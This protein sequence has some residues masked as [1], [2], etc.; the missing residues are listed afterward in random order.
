M[1]MSGKVVS[2]GVCLALNMQHNSKVC[3]QACRDFKEA[4]RAGHE[5]CLQRLGGLG[6][7]LPLDSPDWAAAGEARKAQAW[8]AAAVACSADRAPLLKWL[9]R[10]RWPPS[11]GAIAPWHMPDSFSHWHCLRT[12]DGTAFEHF[13]LKHEYELYYNAVRSSTI[14]CLE[15][16]LEA[17]CRSPWLCAIAAA[18][19]Q[20]GH[21]RLAARAGCPCDIRVLDIGASSG[22][23]AVLKAVY[24]EGPDS[25]TSRRFVGLNAAALTEGLY[26][27][28]VARLSVKRASMRL[29][30]IAE[31]AALKGRVE[32]LEALLTWFGDNTWLPSLVFKAASSGHLD[33]LQGFERWG[34]RP[35]DWQAAAR[36]AALG[37]HVECL[38]FALQKGARLEGIYLCDAAASRNLDMLRYLVEAGCTPWT[39]REAQAAARAGD[40]EVL[41]FCLRH[42]QP[43]NPWDWYWAMRCARSC[44]SVACVRLLYNFGYEQHRPHEAERHP[45]LFA[46]EHG[47]VPCLGLAVQHSGRPDPKLWRLY[48]AAQCGED[49]LRCVWEMGA[50]NPGDAAFGAIFASQAGALRFAFKVGCPCTMEL[51]WAAIDFNSLECLR[52]VCERVL[53]LGLRDVYDRSV[54]CNWQVRKDL[55]PAI[56]QYIANDVDARMS[57]PLVVWIAEEYAAR[58]R[59]VKGGH[60]HGTDGINWRTALL[61]AR[62]FRR[63]YGTLFQLPA[64]LCEL[65]AVRRARAA[66]LAGA[67]YRA[68]KLARGGRPSPSLPLWRALEALPSEL[69][70]RIAFQAHLVAP[71]QEAPHCPTSLLGPGACIQPFPA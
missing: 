58:A 49:M 50:R 68:G 59:D 70:E 5:H 28:P 57:R 24:E 52:C 69:R 6:E 18:E 48:R 33:C 3:I 2:D 17:G 60:V 65:V 23:L 1:I 56:V 13:I 22:R 46:L 25:L 21:L 55:D 62:L 41:A 53:V 26:D 29:T 42:A 40:S 35:I 67:F 16:L 47:N 32:C 19:G 45:A 37:G 43:R 8:E 10:A 27:D 9:F 44:K 14:A 31:G 12:A 61:V 34:P 7:F 39:G 38:K 54:N 51:V 11:S 66:A 15:A 20:E 36:G 71:L 63:E 4:A 64:P 30:S